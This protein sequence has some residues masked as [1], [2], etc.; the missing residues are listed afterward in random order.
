M[1][2]ILIV[3]KSNTENRLNSGWY[4]SALTADNIQK[5]T[6][7]MSADFPAPY[8][9]YV[10]EDYESANRIMKNQ[11]Y[12][13]IISGDGKS[14]TGIDFSREDEKPVLSG[15]VDKH[16]FVKSD[17]ISVALEFS[18]SVPD[19]EYIIPI[20]TPIG[21]RK[22]RCHVVDSV[23]VYVFNPAEHT[24][25]TGNYLIPRPEQTNDVY[26]TNM[27]TCAAFEVGID[28]MGEPI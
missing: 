6:E 15:I 13:V 14:I 18:K 3:E 5:I 26:K 16:F 24:N 4:G 28:V 10:V 7:S 22:I 21:D 2:L 17:S 1:S 23:F 11:S 20:T 27:A 25:S 19:G 9:S 12:D 8:L